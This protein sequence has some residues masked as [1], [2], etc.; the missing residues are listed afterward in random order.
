M[1]ITVAQNL[2]R[3]YLLVDPPAKVHGFFVPPEVMY[4]EKSLWL[5]ADQPLRFLP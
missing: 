2:N 4:R 1:I 5:H 3:F